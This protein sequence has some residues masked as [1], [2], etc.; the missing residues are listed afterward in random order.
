MLHQ[1]RLAFV[2]GRAGRRGTGASASSGR[3]RKPFFKRL[4]R[5]LDPAVLLFLEALWE[6]ASSLRPPLPGTRDAPVAA[7][8]VLGCL[9][10]DLQAGF[11]ER[12]RQ[13]CK[14]DEARKRDETA[15]NKARAPLLSD[16]ETRASVLHD[17]SCSSSRQADIGLY[18]PPDTLA[19]RRT[20]LIHRWYL[21]WAPRGPAATLTSRSPNRLRADT[22]TQDK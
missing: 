17:A 6:C 15:L 16:S 2:P 20:P 4:R 14:I 19:T 10:S 13:H 3:R 22:R 8:P 21:L 7:L 5:F 9:S 18:T 12:G 1:N 11:G